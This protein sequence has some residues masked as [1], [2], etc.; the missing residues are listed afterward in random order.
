MAGN[1]SSE[2]LAR[3]AENAFQGMAPV[4]DEFTAHHDYDLWLGNLLPLLEGHGL[5]GGRL[6]DVACGTGKSFL[7]MW[8]KGW[9]VSACDISPAM[10]RRAEGKVDEGVEFSVADMRALP[11]LGEFDLVF[12]LDDAINYLLTTDELDQTLSSLRRN[13][14]PT[15][16]LMFDANTI[17]PYRTFFAE[18]V[19]VEGEGV[20]LIWHGLSS[21]DAKPSSIYEAT[22]KVETDPE[23]ADPGV[24]PH[25][26]RQRHFS[27][28][29]IGTAL[30]NAGLV[31]LDVFGHDQE[32]IPQ[33][34]LDE[35]RHTKAI[36]IARSAPSA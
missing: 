25:M 17:Q 5:S 12:C 4:Y 33:Q 32:A 13:L 10:I 29:E 18:D 16:L 24:K 3:A 30:Q 27:P 15:G 22:F 34:P 9:Q 11:R 31:C 14:S 2:D 20:R 35:A 26:H 6:L 28:Q 36:Y 1:L 19:V 23:G 7:P 21:S 8:E